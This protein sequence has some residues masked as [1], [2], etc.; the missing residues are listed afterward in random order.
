MDVGKVVGTIVMFG[1]LPLGAIGTS[2]KA[3]AW[4]THMTFHNL[5]TGEPNE[6]PAELS[7]VGAGSCVA[8]AGSTCEAGADLV[9]YN[10]KVCVGYCDLSP[11]WWT[12]LLGVYGH[13]DVYIQFVNNTKDQPV[14]DATHHCT[15]AE[16]A[17]L[18]P[19][20]TIT[21]PAPATVPVPHEQNRTK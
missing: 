13:C 11:V 12:P 19:P 6:F 17:G 9:W 18:K 21:T 7:I 3:Y 16:K 15:A 14:F 4:D 5:L 2:L 20:L 1:I 8:Q 10:A